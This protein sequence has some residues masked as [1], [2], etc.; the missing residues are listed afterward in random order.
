V[1][2][3]RVRAPGLGARVVEE[4]TPTDDDR[5]EIAERA[6]QALEAWASAGLGD[7]VAE[8]TETV[9][10]AVGPTRQTT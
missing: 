5:L 9:R 8:A 3:G 7:P 1:A 6:G 2:P 10:A 4:I